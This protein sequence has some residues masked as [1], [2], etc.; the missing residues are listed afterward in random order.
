MGARHLKILVADDDPAIRDELE[1][2]IRRLGHDVDTAENGKVCLKKVAAATYDLVFLDLFMP[3]MDGVQVMK[4]FREKSVPS[5]VVAIS[6]LDDSDVIRSILKF[7]AAA[8]LIKP[9]REPL[10]R[11]VLARVATGTV[12][13]P[14]GVV[15][16]YS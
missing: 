14:T 7:G 4:T 5:T 12:F 8:F 6:S 13:G 10:I 1:L 16:E 9:L 3:V 15:T 11:E 2:M